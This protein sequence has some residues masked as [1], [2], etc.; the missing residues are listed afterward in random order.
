[1]LAA[2][3]RSDLVETIHDGAVAVVAPDGS[4]IASYGDID[5]PFYLRSSAK[6]FQAFV[7]QR[8]GAD[9]GP[10]ELA[11][12]AASHRGFPVQV[13]LVESMLAG[14][15]VDE[16]ALGCP[17]DWP[18]APRAREAVL[19]GGSARPRRIWHNCSGKHAGFLRACAARGWQ[20]DS[21]LSPM[22]P[23]QLQ[24]AETVSEI[25]RHAVEPLGVDGC[26]APV[27]RTT[28]RVLALL[29]AR[30]A[31]Y[32]ELR[33]V[34]TAMHRYPALVAANGE[35]DAEIAIATNSVAKGGAAGCVGVGVDGRFGV[36]VK[37]WDG[38][39]AVANLAAVAA[40][41]QLGALTAVASSSLEP[42][43]HPPV[44]GGG[45]PV[46]RFEPRFELAFS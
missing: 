19:R 11:M 34:F 3:V 25:G 26:G 29:F 41:G 46:G 8:S 28:S 12:A 32:P 6:P 7:S 36:G 24:V 21:Y 33:A 30:L 14:A 22:H 10:R 15:G 2:Q 20:L 37:S 16:S 39:G 45:R 1:M 38:L 13:A 42:I 9:L 5:R 17:P 23:L 27:L 35:G 4:L 43:V 40:L 31:V 44:L 18:L